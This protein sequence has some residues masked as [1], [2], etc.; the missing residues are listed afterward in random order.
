[1]NSQR[2]SFLPPLWILSTAALVLVVWLI[3]SLKELFVL[4]LLGYF[5]AYAIEP[6]VARLEQKGASRSIAF[7]GVC[8]SAI[9]L[10]VV[11]LVTAFPAIVDEF[12]KLSDNLQSYVQTGRSKLTP[13]LDRL[14]G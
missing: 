1:V 5:I 12:H 8:G 3:I 10:L 6:L 7:F 11:G 4:L 2:D 14:Q 13:A 9:L